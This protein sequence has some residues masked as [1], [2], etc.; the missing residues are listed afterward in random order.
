MSNTPNTAPN[1]APNMP[2]AGTHESP[3]QEMGWLLQTF[4]GDVPGVTHAVLISRDGMRLLDSDVDKDW[5]DEL[6]AA[7]SGV[8]SLAANT[9]GPTHHKR[10]ARQVLIEREDCLFLLQSAGGSKMFANQ[11]GMRGVVDTILLVITDP[12]ADVGTVGYE[13]SRLI[14]KFAPY[15]EIPVRVTPSGDAR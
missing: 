6:A 7:I 3:Q 15:M 2:E 14:D 4:A 5:A 1:T 13:M 12:N 9:T 10:P 11:S 8:A